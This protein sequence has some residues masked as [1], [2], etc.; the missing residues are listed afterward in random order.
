ML[1]VITL[2]NLKSIRLRIAETLH[3]PCFKLS[4]SFNFETSTHW[5]I[6]E[7]FTSNK[8]CWSFKLLLYLKRASKVHFLQIFTIDLDAWNISIPENLGGALFGLEYDSGRCV[9]S[10]CYFVY[11]FRY[12]L[13][14]SRPELQ[15]SFEIHQST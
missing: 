12:R 5:C 9:I 4:A 1:N 6:I 7:N 14:R 3:S 11:V 13:F 15:W 10:R 2:Q 8:I